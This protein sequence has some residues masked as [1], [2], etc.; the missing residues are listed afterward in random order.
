MIKSYRVTRRRA[1]KLSAAAT[2]LPLVHIRTAGAAGKLNVGFWDHWVPRTN[3]VMTK[4]VNTWAERTRS[5]SQSTS[6]LRTGSRFQVTQAAEAQAG[7]GHDMLPFYNWEVQTYFNKLEP[8]DD[9][10]KYMTGRYG[11]YSPVHEYLATATGHWAALPSS[12]GTLNL[13][14]AGRISLLKQYA[15]IDVLAMYPAHEADRPPPPAGTT[16]HSSKPQRGA[17][18]RAFHSGWGLG[19]LA[20]RP[21]TPAACSP[22]LAL[23][24]S[25]PRVKSRSIPTP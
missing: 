24:W 13:T 19:A 3:E 12:T 11:E 22:P 4:Q 6:S 5:M 21:T 20:T 25:T 9:V 23:I 17:R 14:C 15:G 10:V 8:V 2:A 18:R 1:L 7:T 16:M